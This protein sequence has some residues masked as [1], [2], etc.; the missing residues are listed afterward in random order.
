MVAFNLIVLYSN[1]DEI[2]SVE[3]INSYAI[4]ILISFIASFF[5]NAER[6]NDINLSGCNALLGFVPVLNIGLIGLLLI[7]GTKGDNHL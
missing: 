4:V 1:R 7:D 2:D 3:N 6:F 5:L